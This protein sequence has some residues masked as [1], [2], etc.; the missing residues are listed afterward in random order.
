MQKL[1]FITCFTFLFVV[2]ILSQAAVDIPF[3]VTDGNDT[4]AVAVG[5]DLTANNIIHVFPRSL[6]DESRL[7]N[8]IRSGSRPC[9]DRRRCEG[10]RR[11]SSGVDL[12]IRSFLSQKLTKED[13]RHASR[14]CHHPC[15]RPTDFLSPARAICGPHDPICRNQPSRADA[16]E[17]GTWTAP[18]DPSGSRNREHGTG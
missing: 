11:I 2:K 16:C 7:E 18:L 4:V 6:F 3:D 17:Y 1:F 15:T 5:L 10:D 13:Q 14:L 8:R 9:F 12:R